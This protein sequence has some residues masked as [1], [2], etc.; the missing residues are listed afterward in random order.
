MGARGVDT[1]DELGFR[2]GSPWLEEGQTAGGSAVDFADEAAQFLIPDEGIQIIAINRKT[3]YIGSRNT[4]IS[5]GQAG[6]IDNNTGQEQIV[7]QP[8]NLRIPLCQ[9]SLSFVVRDYIEQA[10]INKT[11]SCH[12]FRHTM[13]TVMLE[14][15][16]DIRFIQEMLGHAKL[17]TTQE[18]TRVSIIKLK[19]IH[20]ATHPAARLKKKVE[21]PCSKSIEPTDT[22]H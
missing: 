8:P 18:Y 19:E 5:Y 2:K 14:N 11:G 13:A 21:R 6:I 1:R 4:V 9:D 17:D 7:L 22:V 16:A 3:G 10:Q 20:N 12:L 15:G